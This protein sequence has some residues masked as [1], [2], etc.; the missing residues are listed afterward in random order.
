MRFQ[1]C[2]N[3]IF[4]HHHSAQDE[5]C[6]QRSA[7]LVKKRPK[8][9]TVEYRR[10]EHAPPPCCTLLFRVIVRAASTRTQPHSGRG[11]H[12]VDHLGR[13]VEISVDPNITHAA[14]EHSTNIK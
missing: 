3:V 11:L 8:L 6:R 9:P 2:I 12:I 14:A 10:I 13:H 5:E 4:P 1:N 7:Q